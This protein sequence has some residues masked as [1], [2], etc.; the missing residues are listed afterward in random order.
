[1]R[2]MKRNPMGLL[3][4]LALIGL[5]GFVTGKYELFLLFF[6]AI[7]GIFLLKGGDE[8]MD[9]NLNLACRNAFMFIIIDFVL[10]FSYFTFFTP[11][12]ETYKWAFG[13]GF[14]GTIVALDLT[15][16]Y[17]QLFGE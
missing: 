15:W 4:L 7:F 6:F 3:G 17:Y 2:D 9:R 8:R 14:N 16:I 11:T 5:L 10:T 12:I 1:M 13:I